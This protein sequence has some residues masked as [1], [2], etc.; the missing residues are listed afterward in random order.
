MNKDLV[1]QLWD[2][3]QFLGK[4]KEAFE[5]C[6]EAALVGTKLPNLVPSTFHE[7]MQLRPDY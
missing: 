5:T 7:T 1:N 4:D 6:L 3:F 2:S